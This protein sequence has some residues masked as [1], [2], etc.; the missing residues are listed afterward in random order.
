M[1]GVKN[2]K[3]AILFAVLTAAVL[4]FI[5]G[6]SS[7]PREDSAELSGGLVQWLK[8]ILDPHDR[9]A[10][11]VFHHYIRKLAHFAEFAALGFCLMGLSE[12][13][14]WR[15][16]AWRIAS[17]ALFSA[18]A[19]ATDEFIQIFSPERGPGFRDVL[20]DCFG[21]LCGI[22]CMLFFLH[23]LKKRKKKDR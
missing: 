2:R 9:I 18:A 8:P 13:L 5:F 22:A 1:I 4:C 15:R 20:L 6:N 10:E 7:L 12:Q 16:R 21:A 11:D 17:P 23:I 14:L 3:W 19:A